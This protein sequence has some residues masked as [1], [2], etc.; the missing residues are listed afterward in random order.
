MHTPF[1][2]VLY[3]LLSSNNL[4]IPQ[5]E[6]L[7]LPELTTLDTYNTVVSFFWGGGGVVSPFFLGC[8]NQP[9]VLVGSED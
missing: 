7:L 8:A 5:K 3:N 9:K 1:M 2:D 4:I 6:V